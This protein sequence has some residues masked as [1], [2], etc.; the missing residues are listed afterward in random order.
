[1]KAFVKKGQKVVVKP[2]IGWDVTP[3]LAG[4]TNPHLITRIV[5]HCFDAGAKGHR[6]TGLDGQ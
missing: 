1:M 5:K 3:E 6:L 4:N 2:N